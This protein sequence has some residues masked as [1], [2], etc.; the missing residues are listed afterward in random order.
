[1]RTP[2]WA[3]LPRGSTRVATSIWWSRKQ[4]LNKFLSFQ[5]LIVSTT[6]TPTLVIPRPLSHCVVS[7]LSAVP[8]EQRLWM[9]DKVSALLCWG[10]SCFT[11]ES[12]DFSSVMRGDIVLILYC[13]GIVLTYKLK[14][15]QSYD[16]YWTYS[17]VASFSK[18]LYW[19]RVDANQS[20][21]HST[22]TDMGLTLSIRWLALDGRCRKTGETFY[23]SF[24]LLKIWQNAEYYLCGNISSFKEIT[25]F[26]QL[27]LSPIE[28]YDFEVKVPRYLLE[29]S[30]QKGGS[31]I[32][33]KCQ[34]WRWRCSSVVAHLPNVLEILA[35]K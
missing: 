22:S 28:V 27:F 10:R 33:F 32:I 6:Q 4:R 23:L 12:Q 2:A 31:K 35:L 30:R 17:A 5:R 26:K 7:L 18:G 19:S 21:S 13:G 11:F 29:C 1:M 14:T 3:F 8:P 9:W 24:K 34:C 16:C 15:L 25:V 20:W